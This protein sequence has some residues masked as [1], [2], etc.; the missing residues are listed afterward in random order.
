MLTVKNTHKKGKGVFAEKNFAKG[1]LIE[2]AQIIIIPQEQVKF[3]DQT[4]LYNYYFAW[5]DH[6]AAIAL[7]FGSLYNHSYKPNS[8]YTK[9]FDESIV[10]FIAYR[11]IL[12]GQEITVNYNNGVVDDFSPIWFDAIVD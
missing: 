5:A 2:Q 10:E 12:K 7:G 6:S 3:I 11:D 9:K 4:N 1:D 8:F